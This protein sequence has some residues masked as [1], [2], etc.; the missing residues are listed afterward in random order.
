MDTPSSEDIPA[1]PIFHPDDIGTLSSGENSSKGS[2]NDGADFTKGE[3]ADGNAS[4]NGGAAGS[5][6][7]D[8]NFEHNQAPQSTS[9]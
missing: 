1:I 6:S 7:A 9:P 8:A 5:V 3:E 2:N 4:S